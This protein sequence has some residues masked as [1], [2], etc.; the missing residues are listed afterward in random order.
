M[1]WIYWW[2]LFVLLILVLPLG[3]GWGYRGWGAP[4]PT[5]YRRRRTAVGADPAADR[6]GGHEERVVDPDDPAAREAAGW[7]VAAD[8]LWVVAVVALVWLLIGLL[9]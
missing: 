5:Y 2:L 6:L 3:Y 4:Y 8:V 9:V 1:L 7:G